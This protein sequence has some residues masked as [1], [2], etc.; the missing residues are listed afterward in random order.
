MNTE[1][2]TFFGQVYVI[3]LRSRADRRIEMNE[4]LQRIGLSFDSPNVLLFEATKPTDPAGF[5]TVGARGC[6][7]SHLAVLR[8]AR[9]KGLPSVVILEDDLNFCDDFVERFSAIASSL[10]RVDWGLF[11]GIYVV[12]KP[13][14]QSDS[15][16]VKAGSLLPIGTSAFV[17]LNARCIHAMVDYL[18]AMLSRPPGDPQGGPMHIDGAYCWFRQSHPEISTWLA[19]NQLGFQRSSKTDVHALRWYDR[20]TW[21]AWMVALLRRW[22][23]R[24]RN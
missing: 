7:M 14:V 17:A 19:W 22:R 1:L 3:N 10:G 2:N 5:P 20:A 18:D 4:Q 15:P 16:C 21:S 23:N 12:D 6:F 11:F 13:L 8:D 9:D 24:I